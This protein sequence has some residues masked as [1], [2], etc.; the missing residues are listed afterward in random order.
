M[1]EKYGAS[2]PVACGGKV[3]NTRRIW[4]SCFRTN[5]KLMFQGT[6]YFYAAFLYGTGLLMLFRFT[7][8]VESADR[9]VAVSLFWGIQ[10]ITALYLQTASQEW[11]WENYTYRL[12]R[13]YRNGISPYY[14]GRTLALFLILVLSFL[15]FGGL[16][17]FMFES[18]LSLH[19]L[20]QEIS[21]LDLVLT[22]LGCGIFVSF[23]ISQVGELASVMAI[24]SRFKHMMLMMIMLPLGMPLF[25][26]AASK[27]RMAFQTGLSWDAHMNELAAFSL[28]YAAAG[29]LLYEF[30][31]EE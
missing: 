11:E 23:G 10:F 22:W 13:I 1:R 7:M 27:S 24:H 3:M 25:L 12:V 16:W 19:L 21:H 17:F 30:L 18:S 2:K 6:G 28:I 20:P 14:W 8:P 31:L 5:V 29:F 4:F 15:V 26:T 9:D